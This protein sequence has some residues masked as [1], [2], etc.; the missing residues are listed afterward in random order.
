MHRK[1]GEKKIMINC[2]AKKKNRRKQNER[3]ITMRQG[4]RGEEYN[5]DAV[6]RERS[7]AFEEGEGKVC[8][9]R[10]RSWTGYCD[11][12]NACSKTCQSVEGAKFG[13]CHADGLGMACFCYADC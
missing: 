6:E 10:S 9:W 5:T 13:A 8:K 11:D 2:C 7:R 4:R 12:S 1:G 3:T